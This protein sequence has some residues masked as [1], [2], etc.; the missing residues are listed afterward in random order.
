MTQDAC[1]LLNTLVARYQEA[2]AF[3]HYAACQFPVGSRVVANELLELGLIEEQ[4]QHYVLTR[5]GARL[6]LGAVPISLDASTY[7]LRMRVAHADGR[8]PAQINI[9]D[10]VLRELY[11]RGYIERTGRR[12][13]LLT[14]VGA[15]WM[16]SDEDPVNFLG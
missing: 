16:L 13:W 14:D 8:V 2:S 10:S 4:G 3:R 12:G 1:E 11:A 7:V 15:A 5:V 6:V 9:P